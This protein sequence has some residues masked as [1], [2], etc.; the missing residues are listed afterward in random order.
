MRNSEHVRNLRVYPKHSGSDR[1][2]WG[3]DVAIPYVV[4]GDEKFNQETGLTRY[5]H[6]TGTGEEIGFDR[7]MKAVTEYVEGL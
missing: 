4:K 6:F 1:L 2:V 3:V 7:V 5:H